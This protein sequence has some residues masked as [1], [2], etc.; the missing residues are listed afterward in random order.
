VTPDVWLILPTYNEADNLCSVVA[1][2]RDALSSVSPGSYRI[3]IVDDSSPDGTGRVADGIAAACP[4]VDVL[5]RPRKE[6]LGPAYIAGFGRA[7]AGGAQFVLEMDAD[8]S[9]DPADIPRLVTAASGGCDLAVGSRYVAGGRVEGWSA[10]RRLISRAGCAYARSMLQLPVRDLTAGFKC[11][12]AD[13]LRAIAY[14]TAHSQG[15]AFQVELTYRTLDVGG[16]VSELPIV[17]RERHAGASKMTT[18]IAVE[19]AYM[20]PA[21]RVARARRRWLNRQ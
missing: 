21:L 15:Y 8:W 4:E 9:H 17:F 20:I 5:H 2:A 12:R 10:G 3:L 1:A 14:G 6:G 13:T 18:R 16:R 19:A 11:F 7:L